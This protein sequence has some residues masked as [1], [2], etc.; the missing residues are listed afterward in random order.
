LGFDRRFGHLPET[1]AAIYPYLPVLH[2]PIGKTGTGKCR[3]GRCGSV[4]IFL[5]YIF[6]LAKPELENV[7]QEN[8]SG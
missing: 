3:T 4:L 6:L 5:S 7:G 2:F 1:S 8:M